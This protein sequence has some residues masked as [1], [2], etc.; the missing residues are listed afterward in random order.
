MVHASGTTH[1][2]LALFVR[3]PLIASLLLS[4]ACSAAPV[5][6]PD[7][8]AG[9][10]PVRGGGAA[11][12]VFQALTKAFN[13]QHP[14]VRFDFQD[15]GSSAGMRLLA[16][17]DLDLATSGMAPPAELGS[18]LALVPIGVIG[19]AV[20]VNA[21]NP[22]TDLTKNQV[23]A[24]FGG[25]ISN[26]S[27]VGGRSDKIIVAVREVTSAI[28]MNFDAYFFEGKSSFAPDVIEVTTGNDVLSVVASHAGVISMM[29]ATA[30]KPS[31]QR[32]RA[33]TIDGVAPTREN[34][35]SG[36][37]PVRRPV[38]L[39]YNENR[40]RPAIAAF[41]DFVRSPEGQRIIDAY[42]TGG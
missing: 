32:I 18:S 19:T 11:L 17:G 39:V 3:A 20:I 34:V 26:W 37:Y 31:D 40:V 38:H 15:T 6:A 24:I 41:L 8:L 5:R 2:R 33:V 14:S 10:Y 21:A 23:R 22:V 7:P 35:A 28:R 9:N 25:A 13:R 1:S 27:A 16:S 12:E 36:R 42:S 30:A 4:A 29:S